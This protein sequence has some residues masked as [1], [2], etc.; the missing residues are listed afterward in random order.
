VDNLYDISRLSIQV[1]LQSTH[2]ICG[3]LVR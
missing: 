2:I 1:R 3:I